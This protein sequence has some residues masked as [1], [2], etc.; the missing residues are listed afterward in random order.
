MEKLRRRKTAFSQRA[1]R[2]QKEEAEA[3][4]R[5]LLAQQ[6]KSEKSANVTLASSA[7]AAADPQADS[8]P[9]EEAAGR[10]ITFSK[11]VAHA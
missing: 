3:K 4:G 9:V 1:E 11:D 6:Q 8:K 5:V 10:Y 2:E 7:A